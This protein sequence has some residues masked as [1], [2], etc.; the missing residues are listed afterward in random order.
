MVEES[1]TTKVKRPLDA[2]AGVPERTP[3]VDR[4]SPAGRL[5]PEARAQV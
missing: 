1:V 4:V 2:A 5:L 3:A